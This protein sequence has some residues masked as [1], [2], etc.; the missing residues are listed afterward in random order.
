[1]L[2]LRA[3][4]RQAAASRSA[5]P[6]MRVQHGS[7]GGLPRVMLSSPLSTLAQTPSLRASLGHLA[8]AG[9]GLGV[10]LGLGLGFGLGEGV[11]FGLGEGQPQLP[12][13]EIVVK[14]RMLRIKKRA[15]KRVLLEA[16]VKFLVCLERKETSE[17]AYFFTMV[18]ELG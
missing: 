18:C 5:S 16:I 13:A 8:V 3:V 11:G 6:L 2:A 17:E 10:G 7:T 14:K 1:M 9:L 15:K 12:Q 4:Q